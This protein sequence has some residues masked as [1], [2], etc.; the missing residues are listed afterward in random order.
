M[1]VA[2]VKPHLTSPSD[3]LLTARTMLELQTVHAR[4]RVASL[5]IRWAMNEL[6]AGRIAPAGATMILEEALAELAGETGDAVEED[7]A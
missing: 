3:P 6:T 1:T 4:L 2:A 7:A 5:S